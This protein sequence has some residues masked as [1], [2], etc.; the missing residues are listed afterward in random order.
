MQSCPG[1]C[2]S[3][4]RMPPSFSETHLEF[5]FQHHNHDFERFFFFERHVVGDLFPSPL[6][7]FQSI[8]DNAVGPLEAWIEMKG[9]VGAGLHAAAALQVHL[10]SAGVE[11]GGSRTPR[12][13]AGLQAEAW[14][15]Q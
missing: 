4:V 8:A 2:S 1:C 11:E 10:E 6:F 14:R 5:V 9:H 12:G 3:P 15:A 7:I 13:G